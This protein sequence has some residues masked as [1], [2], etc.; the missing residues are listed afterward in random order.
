MNHN[1]SNADPVDRVMKIPPTDSP[2]YEESLLDQAVAESFPAID[3]ISPAVAA[4]MEPADVQ[5]D[6]G[7][8]N[9]P[10]QLAERMRANAPA[11]IAIATAAV[12]FIA[13]RASRGRRDHSR[14]N[15]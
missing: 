14:R 11:L 2:R 3:P 6:Q 1:S 12:A 10:T 13:M 15:Y 9:A 5:W 4:R 8:T 7:S